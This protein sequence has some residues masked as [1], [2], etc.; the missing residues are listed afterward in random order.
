MG[1]TGSD[2]TKLEDDELQYEEDVESD[3]GAIYPLSGK[4][5]APISYTGSSLRLQA[6][7]L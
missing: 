1:G 6:V 2:E 7:E 3:E 4:Y 5:I